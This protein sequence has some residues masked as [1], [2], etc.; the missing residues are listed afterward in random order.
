MYLL[1]SLSFI[2]PKNVGAWSHDMGESIVANQTR[3]ALMRF[4]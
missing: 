4:D 2:L 1:R 3:D